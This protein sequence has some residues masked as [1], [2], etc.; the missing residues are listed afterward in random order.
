MRGRKYVAEHLGA[1]ADLNLGE[2]AVEPPVPEVL[3]ALALLLYGG[4]YEC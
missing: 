2:P 4:F 3:L 1:P